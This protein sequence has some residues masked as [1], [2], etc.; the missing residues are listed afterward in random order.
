MCSPLYP[1]TLQLTF[2]CSK[3]FHIDG[4]S[5]VRMGAGAGSAC[6]SKGRVRGVTR[7][8]VADSSLIPESCPSHSGQGSAYGIG[9]RIGTF[10][11]AEYA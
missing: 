10:L 4:S 8:R 6:D 5:S 11:A 1:I 9:A 3:I 2:L 7:L